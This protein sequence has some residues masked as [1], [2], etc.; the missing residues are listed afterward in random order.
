[1]KKIIL[2]L[3]LAFVMLGATAQTTVLVAQDPAVKQPVSLKDTTIKNAVYKLYIGPKGGKYILRTS[4]S[5]N[6]YKQYIKK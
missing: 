1:M 2:T 6:V 4:K 3:A 5:G